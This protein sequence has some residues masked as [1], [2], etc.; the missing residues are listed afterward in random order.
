MNMHMPSVTRSTKRVRMSVADR[1]RQILD[2]ATELIKERGFWAV[3]LH[4]VAAACD[5]SVPG[6]LHHFRNKDV[7]LLEL[8][9]QR[10]ASDM[11]SLEVRL[12]TLASTLTLDHGRMSVT[13]ASFCEAL[14]AR[15]ADQPEL[16]RLYAVLEAESLNPD[17]P[18]HAYF[19]A[20]QQKALE[21]FASFC[22]D[23]ADPERKARQVLAT[24]DG[25][26]LQWLRD[27]TT[28]LVAEWRAIAARLAL[29]N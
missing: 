12:G 26:Q 14:V 11:A 16:V 5:L 2:A 28:D 6:V 23:A 9:E 4:D 29:A 25:L 3:S 8:L 22:P 17:H 18:A 27:P 10:D 15:N 1:R 7:L 24:M 21:G 13:L 20:R 19:A